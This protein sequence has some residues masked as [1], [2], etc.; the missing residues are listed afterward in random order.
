ML[1]DFLRVFWLYTRKARTET[2]TD[3]HEQ[4]A[5]DFFVK[6]GVQGERVRRI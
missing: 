4:I 5:T 6:G 2:T 1:H 3:I